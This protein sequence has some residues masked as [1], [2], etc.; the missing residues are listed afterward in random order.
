MSE[1]TVRCGVALGPVPDDF[2]VGVVMAIHIT[3][4]VGNMKQG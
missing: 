2:K 3:R 1:A 4:G